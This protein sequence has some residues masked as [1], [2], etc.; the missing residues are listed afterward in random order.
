MT[1][2]PLGV[3]CSTRWYALFTALQFGFS[4]LRASSISFSAVA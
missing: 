3:S 1:A 2:T 4:A